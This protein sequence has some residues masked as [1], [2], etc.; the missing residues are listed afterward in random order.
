[1]GLL[2]SV[3]APMGYGWKVPG[4]ELHLPS[5]GQFS[6]GFG[7]SYE[8]KRIFFRT[9]N[10][11]KIVKLIFEGSRPN[12]LLDIVLKMLFFATQKITRIPDPLISRKLKK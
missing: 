10:F 6:E 8:L 1:M 12:F 11:Q 2:C 9:E 7:P 3:K 5:C 4:K